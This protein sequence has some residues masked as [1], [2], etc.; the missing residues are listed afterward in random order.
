ME[1]HP[2]NSR[3]LCPAGT[4]VNIIV[5][6]SGQLVLGYVAFF[7]MGA[8]TFALLSAPDPH[9]INMGFWLA[10]IFGVLA[11]TIT[12]VLLGLPILNLRGDYLAIV[13]LG[14][15]EIIRNLIRSDIMTPIPWVHAGSARSPNQPYSDGPFHPMWITCT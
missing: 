7:A 2:W 4:W 9:N 10:L 6:F 15:G 12:G 8:Y 13:T 5:G 11:A 14:F 1:L 3:Y